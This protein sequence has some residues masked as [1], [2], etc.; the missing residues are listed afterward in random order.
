MKTLMTV[1]KSYRMIRQLARVISTLMFW[2]V[3]SPLITMC[4][5]YKAFNLLWLPQLL[6]GVSMGDHPIVCIQ[7]MECFPP[8]RVDVR[9][10]YALACTSMRAPVS[11][12]IITKTYV[13]TLHWTFN[14]FSKK[15]TIRQERELILRCHPVCTSWGS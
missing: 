13:P 12:S 5:A 1:V 9:H 14:K 10:R 3:S 2:R 4:Y 7:P 8:W 15:I 11:N 6:K